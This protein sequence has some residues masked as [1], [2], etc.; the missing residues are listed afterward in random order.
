M[1]SQQVVIRMG[2]NAILRTDSWTEQGLHHTLLLGKL[3]QWYSTYRT[4]GMPLQPYV[5]ACHVEGV[6]T[7]GENPQYIFTK[8][9]CK[10]NWAPDTDDSHTVLTEERE[11]AEYYKN[12]MMNR[13]N[14]QAQRQLECWAEDMNMVDLKPHWYLSWR[15]NSM[16]TGCFFRSRLYSM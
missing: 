9:L 13:A 7:V 14:P 15:S 16:S 3:T 8:V 5:Y 6:P 11:I 12:G 1:S 2:I 10:A 4:S